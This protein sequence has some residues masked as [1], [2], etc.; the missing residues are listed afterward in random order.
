MAHSTP[1]KKLAKSVAASH[2]LKRSSLV[3]VQCAQVHLL[4]TLGGNAVAGKADPPVR[5]CSRGG[6]LSCR[7]IKIDSSNNE[8]FL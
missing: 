3:R 1:S 6:R 2:P 5:G 7:N 8:G 4:L